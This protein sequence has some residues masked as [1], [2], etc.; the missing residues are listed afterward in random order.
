MN[1]FSSTTA[2]EAVVAASRAD[3]WAVLTDPVLLPKLTPLLQRIESDGD[4]WTWHMVQ[5]KGLGVG[6]SPSF[7]EKMTFDDTDGGH[8]IDYTHAPPPG[9]RERT[10]AEGWYLLEDAAGDGGS[11]ATKLSISLTLDVELPLPRSAGRAVRK[12]MDSTMARTGDKFSKN[13]LRHLG[14]R[15]VQPSGR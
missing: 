10:G 7:T 6:I 1:R 8:R 15:G 12:V 5:I 11:V 2:S 3:I 14:V 9:S 13:L 4:L